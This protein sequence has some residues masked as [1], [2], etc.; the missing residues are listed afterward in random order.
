MKNILALV[1]LS[2]PI[3]I[4]C[5]QTTTPALQDQCSVGDAAAC[6]ELGRAQRSSYQ[7][8]QANSGVDK[9]RPVIPPP[10]SAIPP[11]RHFP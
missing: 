7:E 5:S 10:A 9:T 6:E 1:C 8:Q 11:P 4:G 2:I 3:M